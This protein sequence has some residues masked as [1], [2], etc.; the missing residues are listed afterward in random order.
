MQDY[1][2]KNINEEISLAEFFAALWAYKF[3]IVFINILVV[4]FSLHYIFNAEKIYTA[5]SIFKISAQGQNINN[6]NLI[7]LLD[8]SG[9]V[10]NNNQS[11]LDLDQV[12]GREFIESF[13]K[14]VNFYD[15]DYFNTLTPNK[16]G[17]T[18]KTKIKKIIGLDIN[19][20]SDYDTAW[21]KIVKTYKENIK[22]TYSDEGSIIITVN[23][24]DADRT[25]FIANSLMEF[26]IKKTKK[27]KD[28]KQRKQL[29]YLADLL[30]D[31]QIELENAQSA[32]K[33]FTLKNGLLPKQSFNQTSLKLDT[34]REKLLNTS[35]LHDALK[36][37]E[38]NIRTGSTNNKT[39][40]SLS[41]SFPVINQVEF[42]RILGQNEIMTS[43]TWPS[44]TS[45]NA[46]L[47]TL[48]ERKNRLQREVELN[49]K[50][51]EK[52]G[53]AVQKFITLEREAQ[54]ALATYTVLIEQIK[55]QSMSAGFRPDEFEIFEYAT[56]PQKQYSP[57]GKLILILALIL[58][59]IF[60]CIIALSL[61]ILR[62]VYYSRKL[63]ILKVK[64]PLNLSTRPLLSMRNQSFNKIKDL[65]S[66]KPNPTLLHLATE[67][68]RNN[69]VQVAL[70]SLQSKLK[71]VDLAIALATYIQTNDFKIAIINFSEKSQLIKTS[72]SPTS[73][74]S[75][76][77]S[78]EENNI[79]ILQPKDVSRSI[80]LLG[81]K[82]FVKELDLLQKKFN[83]TLL[84][85]DNFDALSLARA[86]AEKNLL[87]ITMVRLKSTK[88][89]NLIELSTLLPVTGLLH[90]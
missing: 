61:S 1:F 52:S 30:A 37:V 28:N 85:A 18:W 8:L 49:E 90:E 43:W 68:H 7:S 26:I 32:I 40:I 60:A 6:S 47:L 77:I 21:L 66:K 55:A 70:T 74:R 41:K 38:L 64:A 10:S 27:T 12:M 86:I 83:L 67:I 53:L 24:R 51:A 22:L 69:A 57:D 34:L 20:L 75:F 63:L 76:Q 29:A 82:E 3:L 71:S 84:C 14:I 25:Y 80:D 56:K 54:V 72:E 36:A 88:S 19:N 78:T 45:V 73:I 79:T 13:D 35:N 62:G 50:E 46:V 16:K 4:L 2:K 89:E 31:A 11:Q 81:K 65:I 48:T 15:D 44:L 59:F 9:V 33:N 42:R 5:S 39:Y 87:H 17:F 58:G 23:H